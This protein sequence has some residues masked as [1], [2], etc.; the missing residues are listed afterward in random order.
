MTGFVCKP[1]PREIRRSLVP[2][3]V[4]ELA[5][6]PAQ[7]VSVLYSDSAYSVGVEVG[8]VGCA[9]GVTQFGEHPIRACLKAS[10][11]CGA[12]GSIRPCSI[13]SLIMRE[14]RKENSRCVFVSL[15][16][17]VAS[18]KFLKF[19]H[20]STPVPNRRDLTF[21]AVSS[22][23]SIRAVLDASEPDDEQVALVRVA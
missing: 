1:I 7:I 6:R 2:R 9:V 13:S 20:D 21:L 19:F 14:L 8:D 18:V 17:I 4:P 11:S 23:I 5:V 12:L 10:S 16:A 22:V 3:K 15:V